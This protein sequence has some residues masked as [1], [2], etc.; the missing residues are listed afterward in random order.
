MIRRRQG[1]CPTG[2]AVITSGGHLKARFVIH[3]V[4]PIWRGGAHQ[5]AEL[6]SHAYRNSLKLAV[7][8]HIRTIAFPSISTGIYGFPIE[9]ASRVAFNT[10]T[11]FVQKESWI[12]EVRFVMFTQADYDVYVPLFQR[13]PQ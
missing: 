5:E 7:E 1:E 9:R 8:T 2:E 10:V 6:L 13:G 11:E 3:A 12:T 4:G